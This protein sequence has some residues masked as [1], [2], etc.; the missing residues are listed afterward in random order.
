MDDML[1]P[2]LRELLEKLA[3]GENMVVRGLNNQLKELLNPDVELL[4]NALRTQI[5]SSPAFD[6]VPKA[7][8]GFNELVKAHKAYQ[9]RYVETLEELPVKKLGI[10]A[11]N[12]YAGVISETVPQEKLD[13]L[14]SKWRNEGLPPLKIALGATQS[15]SR[16]GR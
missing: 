15:L 8:L 9:M 7:L 6:K 16:G 11:A 13:R 12:G 14:L 10:W 4:F 5:L 1:S 3:S 2:K